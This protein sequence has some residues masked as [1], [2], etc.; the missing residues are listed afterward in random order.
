MFFILA[1]R[2]ARSRL[3][4]FTFQTRPVSGSGFG[5]DA[6]AQER[7]VIRRCNTEAVRQALGYKGLYLTKKEA[8]FLTYKTLRF[9]E[10]A[11]KKMPPIRNA[12]PLSGYSAWPAFAFKDDWLLFLYVKEGKERKETGGGRRKEKER[13]E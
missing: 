4:H 7:A 3:L 11:N 9:Y 1:L 10:Y 5:P 2:D 6:R 12:P 8:I 13:K